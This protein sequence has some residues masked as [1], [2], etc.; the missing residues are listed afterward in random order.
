MYIVHHLIKYKTS[1]V[2]SYLMFWYNNAI[3]S[4]NFVLLILSSCRQNYF[5]LDSVVWFVFAWIYYAVCIYRSCEKENTCKV[6]SIFEDM[7][8]HDI[9]KRH[10]EI[11]YEQ[12]TY[13][14]D[15]NLKG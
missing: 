5:S 15:E 13:T 3:C 9:S 11:Q 4:T 12:S 8:K 10:I 14:T 1:C 7:V 2:K 6:Y